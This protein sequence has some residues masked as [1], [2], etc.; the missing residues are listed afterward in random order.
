MKKQNMM[1][2]D[3]VPIYST[4]IEYLAELLHQV[5]SDNGIESVIMNK[6]DTAYLFGAIE[7]LVK[8]E[9]YNSAIQIAKE[10]E[11]NTRLE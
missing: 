6:K 9:D 10:F 2:P 3:W 8:N 1:T 11:E 7:V 4:G 5:L